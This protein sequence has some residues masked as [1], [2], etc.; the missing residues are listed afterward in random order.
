MTR[1]GRASGRARPCAR[2]R[3][4][5][6]RLA[7]L[8]GLAAAALGAAGAAAPARAAPAIALDACAPLDQV[9]LRA[10]IERELAAEPPPA[11][12][13]LRSELTL[14][15]ACSDAQ[16]ARIAVQP[17]RP[18]LPLVRY[19]DLTEVP[20]ELR[21]KLLAVAAAELLDAAVAARLPP[22]PPV[23]PVARAAPIPPA[24]PT[25]PPAPAPAPAAV[26]ARAAAPPPA[27]GRLRGIDLR[28]GTRH[29]HDQN[30]FMAV[31]AVDSQWRWLSVGL[32]AARGT[33][34]VELGELIAY[35]AAITAAGPAACAG[36]RVRACLRARGE[37]G[38]VEVRGR[39]VSA[40]VVA[41]T[42]RER[43][44]QLGALLSAELALGPVV[45]LVGVEGA[46]A[47][48]IIAT[49]GGSD[50]VTLDRALATVTAGVRWRGS[51]GAR[52]RAAEWAGRSPRRPGGT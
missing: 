16:S 43:Y 50:A 23:A 44:L 41:T 12:A 33:T 46:W 36:G 5:R 7:A 34:Q 27:P 14:A 8:A 26:R 29:F 4:P 28:L 9:A 45:A 13:A 52:A 39:P 35:L 40:D 32:T 17:P 48:G 2:D 47:A 22:P 49:A 30:G 11:V 38:V 51:R 18:A 19:V 3:R 24:R 6:R 21:L 42:A 10:A 20:R 31:A 15:V 25:A 37:A 1:R